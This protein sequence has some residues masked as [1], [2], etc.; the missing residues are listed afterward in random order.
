MIATWTYR[1]PQTTSYDRAAFQRQ[2]SAAMWKPDPWPNPDCMEGHDDEP[3]YKLDSLGRP[4]F[5]VQCA[6]CGLQRSTFINRGLA[7]RWLHAAYQM[8]MNRFGTTLPAE[9]FAFDTAAES[10]CWDRCNAWRQTMQRDH[11]RVM[12]RKLR[13][14]QLLPSPILMT[15]EMS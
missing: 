3:R 14:Y 15:E 5:V 9:L 1:F 4:M 2:V 10:A 11:K 12:D 13:A 7:Y 8:D 6:R